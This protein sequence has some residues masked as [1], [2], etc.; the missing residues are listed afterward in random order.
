MDAGV[1]VYK[2]GRCDRPIMVYRD[3]EDGSWH[4]EF[5]CGTHAGMPSADGPLGSVHVEDASEAV[6]DTRLFEPC[7]LGRHHEKCDSWYIVDG[8]IPEA[9]WRLEL[10][11]DCGCKCFFDHF[12][13][14]MMHRERLEKFGKW[15]AEKKARLAK[16]MKKSLE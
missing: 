15:M 13:H 6:K 9:L 5:Y 16:A 7:G 1:C 11:G 8:M 14:D 12:C 10:A 2:C 3:P 4:L